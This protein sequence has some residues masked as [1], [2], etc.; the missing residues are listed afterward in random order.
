MRSSAL[1]SLLNRAGRRTRALRAAEAIIDPDI[2]IIKGDDH[3]AKPIEIKLSG[4]GVAEEGSR[5][6]LWP[7]VPPG[8]KP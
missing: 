6:G 1:H 8:R 7:Y 4:N 3:G 2:I 5:D